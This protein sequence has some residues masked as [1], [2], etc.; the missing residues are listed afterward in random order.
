MKTSAL[1]M[2]PVA[3]AAL[4]GPAVADEMKAQIE[5]MKSSGKPEVFAVEG[6]MYTCSSCQPE[7]KVKANGEPQ[8][9][10]G[11]ADYDEMRVKVLDPHSIGV[12][13]LRNGADRIFWKYSVSPDGKTLTVTYSD[14]TMKKEQAGGY[15]ATRVA[16]G[17]A[18]SLPVS[19]SWKVEQI[20]EGV[21]RTAER[22][23]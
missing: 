5:A 4:A 1:V 15:T 8:K 18:G 12:T 7:V 23:H 17:P 10:Q 14:Y 9:I 6:G 11:N 22:P 16:P 19:G 3:F 13:A 21:Q 20:T 2:L